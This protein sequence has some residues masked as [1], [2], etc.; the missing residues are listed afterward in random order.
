M[1]PLVAENVDL[2]RRVYDDS[3]PLRGDLRR[4]RDTYSDFARKAHI[5]SDAVRRKTNKFRPC[6]SALRPGHRDCIKLIKA[7]FT[8]LE[9]NERGSEISTAR[10]YR[11]GK[12]ALRQVRRTG[13]IS[14]YHAE[15]S[16]LTSKSAPHLLHKASDKQLLIHTLRAYPAFEDKVRQLFGIAHIIGS[17]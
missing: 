15:R 3:V 2:L 7:H 4:E 14:R 5:W 6:D 13:Y 8:A 12:A 16:A 10:V 1:P 17:S 11:H 9:P